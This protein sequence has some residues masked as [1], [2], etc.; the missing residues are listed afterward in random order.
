MHDTGG[1]FEILDREINYYLL[2]P[3]LNRQIARPSAAIQ[4]ETIPSWDIQYDEEDVGYD[5]ALYVAECL[6]QI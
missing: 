6:R 5:I 1:L 4:I 3:T 2:A